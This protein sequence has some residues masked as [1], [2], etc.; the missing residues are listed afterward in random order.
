MASAWEI[1][2]SNRRGGP[3]YRLGLAASVSI[4]EELGD[5]DLPAVLA[6]TRDVSREGLCLI[7]TTAS[8]GCH[9]LIDGAH[10]L[11]IT[12][13]L[14]TGTEIELKCQV[15]YCLHHKASEPGG[16]YFVGV[17]IKGDSSPGFAIYEDFI[18]SL[19]RQ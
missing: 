14:P 10:A 11:R 16:E 2:S 17:R 15:V 4:D 1:I 19:Y 3:R 6:R 13:A 9:N 7:M 5:S 8:L 18:R 12:L